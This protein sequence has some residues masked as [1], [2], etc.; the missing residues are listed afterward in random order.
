MTENKQTTPAAAAPKKR[1]KR[2]EMV[3]VV[4]SDRMDKTVVVLVQH[5][6]R[7]PAYR[8]YLT[9][10][11]KYK[12]HAEGN[13]RGV[14]EKAYRIGDKVLIVESRPMSREKRWTVSKL[15]ERPV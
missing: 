5:R 13:A 15:V 4:T 8:K 9:Q 10:R 12:A 7:H 2:R 14:A 6:V 3:G 11:V 1:G